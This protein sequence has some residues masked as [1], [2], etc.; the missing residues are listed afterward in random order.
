MTYTVLTV[1]QPWAYCIMYLGK[2]IENRTRKTNIRGTI[3]IHASKQV[4]YD[5]YYWLKAEGYDLPPIDKLVTGKILGM[6]DLI[7]C[8]QEHTSVW[9]E[10]GT[11]GYVLQKPQPLNEPIAAKGNLGFWKYSSESRLVSNA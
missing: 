11:W 1:R 4:D 9:K 5:A 10:K 3:A 2:D 7:D 8:V 6:V